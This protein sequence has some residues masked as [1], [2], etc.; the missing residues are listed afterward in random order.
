MG[1]GD[2]L[3]VVFVHGFASGP[4]VWNRFLSLIAGDTELDFVDA[5]AVQYATG[6][7]RL[8]PDRALP[9]LNTVADH[10]K[11]LLETWLAG[12]PLVLVGHSMGGLVI[13]RW[14]VR[15]LAEG[16][17]LE[18]ARVRRVVLLSC[19][20]AGSDVAR[21]ARRQLLGGNPQERQL[22]TLDEDVRD[23]HAAVL[24]DIVGAEMVSERTCPI[25]FSVYAAESDAVVPRASAQGAFPRSGVLPGDHFS[26]VQPRSRDHASYTTLRSL[27]RDEA[28]GSDPPAGRPVSAY[29]PKALEVHGAP[30]PGGWAEQSADGPPTPYLRRAH[31]TRL[32]AALD[33]ALRG[34]TPRLLVLTGESATGKTRALYEALCA[35]APDRPLLTPTTASDLLSL[36]REGRVPDGA[37][38]WLNEAQRFLYG[39]EGEA[40]ADALHQCLARDEHRLVAVAT[41]WTRPY[42]TQLTSPDRTAHAGASALLTHAALT[43]RITVP[44]YLDKEDM[45]AWAA[46]ER[47]EDDRRLGH[48]LEAGRANGRVIQQLTGGPQLLDAFLSGPETFFTATEYALI[49]VALDARRLGHH[50]PMAAALLARV[51]DG[52]L[53]PQQRSG[54][55]DWASR[56]LTAL[57]EGVREDGTPT[58]ARTLTALTALRPHSGAPALYEPADYLDHHARDL[59]AGQPPHPGLWDALLE[60]ADDAGDLV[61]LGRSAWERG[62]RKHAALLWRR[63][64]LAGDPSAPAVLASH[65]R[66]PLDS[67]GAAIRWAAAH[68]PLENSFASIDLLKALAEAEP[69]VGGEPDAGAGSLVRRTEAEL[70]ARGLVEHL[71]EL[72]LSPIV[73]FTILSKLWDAG[74]RRLFFELLDRGAVQRMKLG[75]PRGWTGLPGLLGVLNRADADAARAAF[76]ARGPVVHLH[77]DDP[78]ETPWMLRELLI[79]GATVA[80]DAAE[81]LIEH[82]DPA[83]RTDIRDGSAVGEM[84]FYLHVLRSPTKGVL[85]ARDPVGHVNLSRAGDVAALLEGLNGVG[86]QDLVARLLARDPVAHVELSVESVAGAVSLVETLDGLGAA[87]EA[88]ALRARMATELWILDPEVLRALRS[89]EPALVRDALMAQYPDHDQDPEFTDIIGVL[90]SA[91]AV[92]GHD[93]TAVRDLLDLDPAAHA[94][95]T[96]AMAIALLIQGLSDVGASRDLM[97]LLERHPA[98]HAD[99]TD[100]EGVDRLLHVLRDAGAEDEAE[101]LAE[102]AWEAGIAVPSRLL[103]YG[104]GPDGRPMPPWTWND[105]PPVP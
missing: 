40:A 39:A 55:A 22:R 66:G 48:A 75:P 45:T 73:L 80:A 60:H 29:T 36:L 94:D 21:G 31:D 44:P 85:L 101:T 38:L 14:L 18:L 15:M 59:R 25:P 95:L 1:D 84:L 46:L 89:R 8:R 90:L 57:S 12:R 91:W 41:L 35:L 56:D 17:G 92:V 9:S 65:V 19:P 30:L 102:R 5:R 64:V 82:C 87:S 6:F 51:A 28:S 104:C 71:E 16:R 42:W 78:D 98:A 54:A 63:S 105:L 83:G 34:G 43:L 49:S 88:A 26:V 74:A 68:C 70:R 53:S 103:P 99:T 13:Q 61:R 69:D 81:E 50:A 27:L 11:T 3:G 33:V 100:T 76:L 52:A 20:N 67:A 86:A 37:V 4:K 7:A 96:D 79:A 24:R 47:A 77:R 72:S 10:L 2:R 93:V 23:T 62:M 58:D 97:R 32:R